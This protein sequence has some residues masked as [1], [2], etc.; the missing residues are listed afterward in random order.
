MY[1]FISIL[2]RISLVYDGGLHQAVQDFIR[3][4]AEEHLDDSCDRLRQS[5]DPYCLAGLCS[6]TSASSRAVYSWYVFIKLLNL[7][8]A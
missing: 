5:L 2:L 6:R 3:S 4:A 1:L 8:R 7:T